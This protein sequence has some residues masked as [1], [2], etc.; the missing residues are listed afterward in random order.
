M[1]QHQLENR[2][3]SAKNVSHKVAKK[4]RWVNVFLLGLLGLHIL[5]EDYEGIVTRLEEEC[6]PKFS[7]QESHGQ[8]KSFPE[9]T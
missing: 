2:Y 5:P 9:L 7:K 3:V 6:A 4:G 8:V 1:I